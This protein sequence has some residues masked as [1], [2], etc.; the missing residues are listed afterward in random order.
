MKHVLQTWLEDYLPYF[1]DTESEVTFDDGFVIL[2]KNGLSYFD[3]AGIETT[4]NEANDKILKIFG[5]AITI[6]LKQ[7]GLI[8]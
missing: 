6:Y 8:K 4:L 5:K 7:W 2:N 3:N 1:V